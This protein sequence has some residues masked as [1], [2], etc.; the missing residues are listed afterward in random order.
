M[1]SIW[2]MKV[3][4]VYS[5][6]IGEDWIFE[7]QMADF[8]CKVHAYDPVI[9]EL[10]KSSKKNLHFYPIGIGPYDGVSQN[11]LTLR[12][13]S[14]LLREN[15]DENRPITYLKLDVEKAEWQVLEQ[16]IQE[17]ETLKNIRDHS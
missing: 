4:L 2:F 1:V 13:L 3:L 14:T 6:G 7:E 8:G 11:N 17:N 15:E 9:E 5:F 12:K 10:P 16:L